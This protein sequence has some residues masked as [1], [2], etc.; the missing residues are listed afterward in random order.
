MEE[1]E[2]NQRDK[3]S[4]HPADSREA[5]EVESKETKCLKR[6]SVV[7]RT[8]FDRRTTRTFRDGVQWAVD[9]SRNSHPHSKLRIPQLATMS[10]R[11]HITA[12]ALLQ[13]L[14]RRLSVH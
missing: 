14:I 6:G 1:T 9:P 11:L 5:A 4:F 13:S 2:G 12:T 10:P 8:P 7:V 3:E